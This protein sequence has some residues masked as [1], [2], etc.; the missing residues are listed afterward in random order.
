MHMI[1]QRVCPL[2]GANRI[3]S[4][5]SDSGD[6]KQ[7]RDNFNAGANSHA[8]MGVPTQAEDSALHEFLS[9]S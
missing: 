5:L 8:A 4:R 9:N 7:D 6:C 2:P 3:L 1:N